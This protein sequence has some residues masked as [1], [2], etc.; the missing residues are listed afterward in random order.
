MTLIEFKK[1]KFN[2][3]LHR[4][5]NNATYPFGFKEN[6]G[7]FIIEDSHFYLKFYISEQW[8][9]TVVQVEIKRPDNNLK[10]ELIIEYSGHVE[11]FEYLKNLYISDNYAFGK[12]LKT[13]KKQWEDIDGL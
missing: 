7:Y 13:T 1:T 10:K 2:T 5:L 3:I 11:I 9:K 8:H 4:I 12:W 6:N